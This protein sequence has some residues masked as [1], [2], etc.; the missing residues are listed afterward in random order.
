[1]KEE[2]NNEEKTVLK[3]LSRGETLKEV[4]AKLGISMYRIIGAR[5]C[6]MVKLSAKNQPHA[7]Y[8]ALSQGLIE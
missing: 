8:L 4:R 5:D 1:M 7:V 3:L 2:L 6:A